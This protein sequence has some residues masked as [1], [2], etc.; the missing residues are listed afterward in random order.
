MAG[1]RL[2]IKFVA[3]LTA[4]RDEAG[5]IAT[6]FDQLSRRE[7]A[8]QAVAENVLSIGANMMRTGTSTHVASR[9]HWGQREENEENGAT[10]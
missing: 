2:R 1:A 9:V 5:A 10:G 6:H 4:E 7:V 3:V 8:F